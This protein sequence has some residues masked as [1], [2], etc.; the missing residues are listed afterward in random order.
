MTRWQDKYLIFQDT[1]LNKFISV[2]V[3]RYPDGVTVYIGS[4][5]TYDEDGLPLDMEV[6]IQKNLSYS[7]WSQY[8]NRSFPS[9]KFKKVFE[10]YFYL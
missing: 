6:K 8:L 9:S 5:L 3:S 7:S 1:I 4:F 2:K 10:S